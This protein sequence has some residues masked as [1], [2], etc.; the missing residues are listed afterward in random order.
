MKKELVEQTNKVVS[1]MLD[2]MSFNEVQKYHS[3]F[4]LIKVPSLLLQTIERRV[5]DYI[6]K[7]SDAS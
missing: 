7:M 2:M 4:K 1:E 5:R 6:Y 3:K